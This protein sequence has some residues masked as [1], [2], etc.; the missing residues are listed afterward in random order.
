MFGASFTV[1]YRTG[2]RLD[3][4]CSGCRALSASWSSWTKASY[5]SDSQ[6]QDYANPDPKIEF[7]PHVCT[8]FHKV[9]SLQ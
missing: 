8:S 3:S 1:T 4:I 6:K 2:L 9:F 5:Q 7:P